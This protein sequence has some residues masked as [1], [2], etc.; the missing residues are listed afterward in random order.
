MCINYMGDKKILG[1]VLYWYHTL[2]VKE[3]K[4]KESSW[5]IMIRKPSD[6]T[7]TCSIFDLGVVQEKNVHTI[8]R[9]EIRANL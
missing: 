9:S 5:R 4:L 6:I 3:N 7:S 1:T 2:Q 8:A